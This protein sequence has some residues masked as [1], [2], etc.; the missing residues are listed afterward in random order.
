MAQAGE[1][2]SNA[3]PSVTAATTGDG[4]GQTL[5]IERPEGRVRAAIPPDLGQEALAALKPGA[6][7]TAAVRTERIDLIPEADAKP[8]EGLAA[9]I[10]DMSF[11]GGQLR[12]AAVLQTP[13]VDADAGGKKAEAAGTG[14][15]GQE[16][17][18]SRHGIDSPLDVGDTVRVTWAAPEHAVLVDLAAPAPAL[19]EERRP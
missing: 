9:V 12:I 3:F 4:R 16:I 17:I 15:G 7:V 2:A 19:P 5:I 10:R 6:P 1:A 11:A 14:G 8:G 13:P 18:A